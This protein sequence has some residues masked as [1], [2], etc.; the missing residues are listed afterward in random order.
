MPKVFKTALRDGAGLRAARYV[1]RFGMASLLLFLIHGAA[2]VHADGDDSR[3]VRIAVATRE[4]FFG[5]VLHGGSFVALP[6]EGSPE[7][8]RKTGRESFR[9]LLAQKRLANKVAVAAAKREIE[10]NGSVL[11][12]GVQW[13][14][15]SSDG[16]RVAYGS[17]HP[18]IT[19]RHSVTIAEG[20]R[21]VYSNSD[22]Q[23]AIECLRWLPDS[24][25]LAILESKSHLSKTPLGVLA[26]LTGHGVPVSR[27]TLRLVSFEGDGQIGVA[28]FE[29]PGKFEEA[30]ACLDA[31]E[32]GIEQPTDPNIPK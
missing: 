21:I 25:T 20:Q 19:T 30:V 6:D 9:A 26:A 28:V 11:P 23:R 31:G 8:G 4:N 24:K 5:F 17:E 7:R 27:Y 10:R 29:L 14:N 13:A 32:Q 22:P 1:F 3:D 12:I 15:F 2:S 16:K 18:D